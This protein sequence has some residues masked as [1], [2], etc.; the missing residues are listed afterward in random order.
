[1]KYGRLLIFCLCCWFQSLAKAEDPMLLE[2][3]SSLSVPQEVFVDPPISGHKLT[4]ASAS[5]AV[6]SPAVVRTRPDAIGGMELYLPARVDSPKAAIAYYVFSVGR[7][8][9]FKIKARIRADFTGNNSLLVAVD[10]S[11]FEPWNFAVGGTFAE[12]VV[13]SL[14]LERGVHS[15]VLKQGSSIGVAVDSVGV[16]FEGAIP[17]KDVSI[18][19]SWIDFYQSTGVLGAGR[20]P[21]AVKGSKYYAGTQAEF[22]LY[23]RKA[24]PGDAI[25]IRNG[26][27]SDLRIGVYDFVNGNK[28]NPIVIRPE[29]PRGVIFDGSSSVISYGQHICIEG[30]DFVGLGNSSLRIVGSY[31][32]LTNNR[33]IALGYGEGKAVQTLRLMPGSSHITLDHNI[34]IATR[35]ISVAVPQHLAPP[36]KLGTQYLHIHHNTFQDISRVFSNGGEAIMLGYGRG[37][38]N[39]VDNSFYGLIEHNTF[40]RASGDTEIISLKSEDNI[41]RHNS[42]IDC[43]GHISSRGGSRNT[44][45]FNLLLHTNGGV[46]LTGDDHIVHGNIMVLEASKSAFMLMDGSRDNMSVLYAPARQSTITNNIVIG[47]SAV[48]DCLKGQGQLYSAAEDN[49][50]EDNIFLVPSNLAPVSSHSDYSYEYCIANNIFRNNLF[51]SHFTTFT[52]PEVNSFSSEN[53]LSRPFFRPGEGTDII[54][55][56]NPYHNYLLPLD[57]DRDSRVTGDD[58][59]IVLDYIDSANSARL[60]FLPLDPDPSFWDVNNDGYVTVE[61][62]VL[63]IINFLQSSVAVFTK[64]TEAITESAT[65]MQD[66]TCSLSVNKRCKKKVSKGKLCK[67]TT[68]IVYAETGS[69]A[70]GLSYSLQRKKNKDGFV[71]FK[72][73]TIGE[74][75]THTKR[76]RVN[77]TSKYRSVAV[78]PACTSNSI[79]IKV[80]EE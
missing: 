63:P 9:Y 49:L 1:M 50:I 21:C 54:R 77:K 79:R 80:E 16:Q 28:D 29:S 25:V 56:Y 74:D 66:L 75:G 19:D 24:K 72:S 43:G 17:D 33:F 46:R 26:R 4:L 20:A 18:H 59:L 61:G 14:N 38:P 36:Y 11:P 15:I 55:D 45:S 34:F 8:G 76:I 39:A 71:D 40:L 58:A 51:W 10:D 48:V 35:G 44:I 5:A 41:V 32:R 3:A 64:P 65:P 12:K 62:D 23:V 27:Y 53:Q 67:L 73:G 42:F 68:T 47:A 30:F 6:L 57:V 78:D 70:A 13:R 69:P 22:E 60:P 52:L 31:T 37:D 2:S 7:S